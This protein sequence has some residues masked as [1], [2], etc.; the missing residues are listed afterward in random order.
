M[1]SEPPS[2]SIVP[3]SSRASSY[4]YRGGQHDTGAGKREQSAP[5]RDREYCT[6]EGVPNPPSGSHAVA[7]A[8]ASLLF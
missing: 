1:P 3:N 8:A 4:L 7:V 6:C 5:G 2:T